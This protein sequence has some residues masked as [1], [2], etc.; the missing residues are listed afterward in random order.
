MNAKNRLGERARKRHGLFTIAHARAC[1]VDDRMRRRMEAAGAIERVHPRVFRFTG[2]GWTWEARQVAAVLA[3]GSG[4]T[5]SHAGAARLLGLPVPSGRPEVTVATRGYPR[6]DGVR[7]HR[8]R[9]L[10][11]GD[12]T[13]AH[14]VACTT[15]SRTLID[16]AG[17][18]TPERRI[19]LVDE[20]ICAGAASRA[21]LHARAVALAPGR[22][23]VAT[24]ADVTRPGAEGAFWS[25]LERRFGAGIRAAGLPSPEYNSP[26]R[27]RGRLRYV[28][29]LWRRWLVV[30]ELHG[31]R[32]H[33]APAQRRA[34]SERQNELTLAGYRCLVFTWQDVFADMPRV[35]AT[36][37]NAL[38][39]AQ[40]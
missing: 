15:G 4:A 27:I 21:N 11:P 34:D 32:F 25:R 1:G 23:G 35:A 13:R 38:G 10:D 12:V 19:A 8:T 9:A 33:D 3:C 26:I 16:L 7:V 5:A 40:K 24:L 36:V 20:A 14:G 29:A 17:R 28:D 18:L 6:L 31:L 39:V 22:R 37:A 30:V 2:S